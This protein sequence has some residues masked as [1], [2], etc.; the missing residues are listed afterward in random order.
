MSAQVSFLGGSGVVVGGWIQHILGRW[1][2]FL[3]PLS[4]PGFIILCVRSLLI[5]GPEKSVGSQ[6]GILENTASTALLI[7]QLQMPGARKL[8]SPGGGCAACTSG[9]AAVRITGLR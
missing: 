9:D 8:D 7:S 3:W 6:H 5:R 4:F 1:G 2:S